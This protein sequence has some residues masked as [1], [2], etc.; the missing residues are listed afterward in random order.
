M[1]GALLE[2]TGLLD[3]ER[4]IG[5]LRKLVKNPKWFDLDVA[6]LA[7]GREEVRHADDYLWGV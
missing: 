3:Q 5:A 4:V 2:A 7:R 6:A 1:L